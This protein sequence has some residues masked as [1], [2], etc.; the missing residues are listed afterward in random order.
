MLSMTENMNDFLWNEFRQPLL[1]LEKGKIVKINPITL[2]LFQAD[3]VADLLGIDFIYFIAEDSTASGIYNELWEKANQKIKI[4]KKAAFDGML[5]RLTGELF[6]CKIQLVLVENKL[7]IQ[8]EDKSQYLAIAATEDVIETRA[9]KHNKAL[10]KVAKLQSKKG[11]KYDVLLQHSTQIIKETLAV[12]QVGVWLFNRGQT[13]LKCIAQTGKDDFDRT[14]SLE[15]RDYET[16]FSTLIENNTLSINI[17]DLHAP[18][19]RYFSEVLKPQNINSILYMPIA[20]IEKVVGFLA[21]EHQSLRLWHLD[22]QS[23]AV[24]MA[25]VIAQSL[26][27]HDRRAIRKELFEQEQMFKAL[28][29]NSTDVFAIVDENA[30]CNFVSPSV[31]RIFGYSTEEIKGND[32]ADRL[33]PDDRVRVLDRLKSLARSKSKLVDIIIFRY[34]HKN[35][36][37][38]YVESVCQNQLET[39]LVNGLVVNFRNIDDRMRMQQQ[40]RE[41]V[42]AQYQLLKTQVNPHF[43][44]N[45]LNTLASLIF[46]NQDDA[47]D[48]VLKLA[49]VYR[50]LLENRQDDTASLA[51]ELALV[52]NYLFL[53]KYRFGDNLVVNFNIPETAKNRKVIALSLQL[54]LENAVKHNEISK[55]NP[56]QVE[57]FVEEDFLVICN[58]FQARKEKVDSTG[59]GINNIQKRY[60]LNSNKKAQFYQANNQFWAKLP[61]LD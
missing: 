38:H 37:Y 41:N 18:L 6:W 34:K 30:I 13:R 43:L 19:G 32:G 26:A 14:F 17:D 40:Q 7:I 3:K 25:E 42:R 28:I 53:Q 12:K 35:G 54:V 36:T 22:E 11:I 16:L 51:N 29:E 24:S 2:Q 60:A 20:D 39:P 10:K 31:E 21:I 47:E 23:F 9:I 55:A 49:S 27:S 52:D 33:H 1:I 5:R 15:K 8:I 59:I 50:Y 57:I 58:N 56:L 61:F 48:F 45:C 4:N 44:F 46:I